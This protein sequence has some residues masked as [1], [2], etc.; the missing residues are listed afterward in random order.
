MRD[1]HWHEGTI[2]IP[3]TNQIAHYWVKAYEEGSEY[4]INGGKI[5]KL[6][7]RID[8]K[9]TANYD[10]GWDI[11]PDENDEATQIAYCILL[12]DYN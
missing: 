3:T 2:G 9:T 4:G 5:S 10:R 11:E 6:E 12:N 1:N 7:I 8:G